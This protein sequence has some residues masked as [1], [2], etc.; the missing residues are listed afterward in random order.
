MTLAYANNQLNRYIL[1]SVSR[2]MEEGVGFGDGDGQSFEYGMLTGPVTTFSYCAGVLLSGHIADRYNKVKLFVTIMVLWC[3]TQGLM[4]LANVYWL[5]ALL[6]GLSSVTSG[7]GVV[8][9]AAIIADHFKQSARGTAIGIFGWGPPIGQGLVYGIGGA[10]TSAVNYRVALGVAA[11]WGIPLAAI[12]YFTVKERNQRIS[13]DET[14]PLV[15]D[16]QEPLSSKETH[17]NLVLLPL[18]RTP[19]PKNLVILH[20]NELVPHL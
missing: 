2:A 11:G 10:L 6:R 14:S 18:N 12:M 9:G 4:G 5:L 1:S 3:V 15:T 7:G 13:L 8:V 19:H 16:T 17:S 20:R